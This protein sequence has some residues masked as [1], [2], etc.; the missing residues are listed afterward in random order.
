MIKQLRMNLDELWIGDKVWIISRGETGIFEGLQGARAKIKI[1]Y[2]HHLFAPDDLS[3]ELKKEE[4]TI[5]FSWLTEDSS[6]QR[7]KQ[8]LSKV[9]VSIDLHI[10]ILQPDLIQAAPAR[11]LDYQLAAC[12]QFIQSAIQK[13]LVRVTIIHGIGLGVLK[14]EVEHVL[15]GFKEVKYC[16]PV[17]QDGAL[18]VWLGP[19]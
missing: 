17:N 1:G 16:L 6:R 12:R 10:E 8:T 3:S 18:E 9:P 4:E 2:E 15:K 13:K 11:I 7:K 19:L 14:Q 5:D